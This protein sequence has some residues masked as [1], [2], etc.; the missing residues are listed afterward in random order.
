[1]GG[2]R[3]DSQVENTGCSCR[4]HEFNSQPPQ[5]TLQPFITVDP[6]DPITYSSVQTCMQTKHQI[7][8][9]KINL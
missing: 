5:G 3:D 1:M 4:R 7:T 2:W 8:L 6:S 9:K